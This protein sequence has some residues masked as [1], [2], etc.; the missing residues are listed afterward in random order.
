M[1]QF[2]SVLIGMYAFMFRTKWACWMALFFFYT[3]SINTKLDSRLQQIFTGLSII[4]ISFVNIYLAPAPPGPDAG[5]A[6]HAEFQD[7]V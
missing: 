7:D 1:Y 5:K 4:L 3:S 6:P 2:F